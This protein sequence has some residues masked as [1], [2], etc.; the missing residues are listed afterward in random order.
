MVSCTLTSGAVI[1]FVL[2]AERG[3]LFVAVEAAPYV[4]MTL[5][6][7]LRGQQLRIWCTV[8][9]NR[10]R[11]SAMAKMGICLCPSYT[12]LT[13]PPAVGNATRVPE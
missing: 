9:I 3:H 11:M 1:R 10:N 4:Q 12:P 6:A 13:A 5:P 7:D 8:G 2:D